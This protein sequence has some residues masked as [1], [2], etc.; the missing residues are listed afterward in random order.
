MEHVDALSRAP[1]KEKGGIVMTIETCEDEILVFRRN[2]PKLKY[3]KTIL[4]KTE[5]E[6]TNLEKEKVKEI[7]IKEGLIFKRQ[8]KGE[9]YLFILCAKRDEKINFIAIRYHDLH[10][11]LGL[12]KTI[13]RIKNFYYF[14]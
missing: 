3:I 10:S 12:D 5:I 6:R 7:V 8:N 11:H 2:D 1:I 13:N 4:Q 14:T 9:T